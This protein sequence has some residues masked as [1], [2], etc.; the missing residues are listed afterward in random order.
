MFLTDTQRNARLKVYYAKKGR[1]DAHKPPRVSL[2]L[3]MDRMGA[4]R[5]DLW[6]VGKDLNI[7]FFV[8]DSEVKETIE[9]EHQRIGE[10]L[11]DIF[12]TVAVSVVVNEK[13]IAEFEGEEL[14][15]PNRR[16]VD[17]SI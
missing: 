2:L 14:T 6:M 8:K 10:M 13:K 9:S 5:T 16:Q 3:D 1:D 4:V 15:V 7:T 11:K 12:N 17:L